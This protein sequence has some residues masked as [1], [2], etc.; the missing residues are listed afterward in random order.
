VNVSV[1][2]LRQETN[3]DQNNNKYGQHV[4]ETLR[5]RDARNDGMTEETEQPVCGQSQDNQL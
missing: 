5:V 3:D 2:Q 1:L 4:D